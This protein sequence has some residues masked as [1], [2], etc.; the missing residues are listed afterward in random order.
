V[1]HTAVSK[2]WY[3]PFTFR[4]R[5]LRRRWYR[6][7]PLG[8]D[9]TKLAQTTALAVS[10]LL[11]NAHVASCGWLGIHEAHLQAFGFGLGVIPK[12]PERE[13]GWPM[14]KFTFMQIVLLKRQGCFFNSLGVTSN[15]K[16]LKFQRSG[17][18]KSS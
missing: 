16:V 13:N 10:F 2:I 8:K 17:N 11:A 9:T 4:L 18:K 5:E 6:S 14:A 15:I 3:C 7:V 12:L 1:P